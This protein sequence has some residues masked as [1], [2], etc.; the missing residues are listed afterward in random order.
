MPDELSQMPVPPRAAGT[1][2][3]CG[4]NHSF[5]TPH[6]WGADR[7]MATFFNKH[8]VLPTWGDAIAHCR[9][10]IRNNWSVVLM[11]QGVTA[12]QL[13]PAVKKTS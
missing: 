4:A 5:G 6:K 12:E 9:E 13:E 10:D 3:E 7:Y 8:G 11:D 1:C 2:D